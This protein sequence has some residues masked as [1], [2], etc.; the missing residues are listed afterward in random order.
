MQRNIFLFYPPTFPLDPEIPLEHCNLHLIPLNRTTRN[1]Y[2]RLDEKNKKVWDSLKNNIFKDK[3]NNKDI[4]YITY[5]IDTDKINNLVL[6]KDPRSNGVYTY[7][8]INPN[9]LKIIE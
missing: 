9:F 3:T 6:Y 8:H 1:F 2:N 4:D 7:N 5:E